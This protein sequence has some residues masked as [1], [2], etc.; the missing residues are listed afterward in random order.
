[1][2]FVCSSLVEN[3]SLSY[4]EISQ[5]IKNKLQPLWKVNSNVDLCLENRCKITNCMKKSKLR[6]LV[7]NWITLRQTS[8]FTIK[9]P[10]QNCLQNIFQ[11]HYSLKVFVLCYKPCFYMNKTEVLMNMKNWIELFPLRLLRMTFKRLIMDKFQ[12]Q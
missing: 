3:V 9:K 8:V 5:V 7:R 12:N 6:L 1:M 4:F 11:G 10:N 2:K